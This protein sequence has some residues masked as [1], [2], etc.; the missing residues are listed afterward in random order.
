M[1]V[2]LLS[3]L[4][5]AA[6]PLL[7]DVSIIVGDLE[8]RIEREEDGACS[9][10][11]RSRAATCHTLEEG[12]IAASNCTLRA[13]LELAQAME[14]V[15]T[16]S[17]TLTGG[18]FLLSG[19]LPEVVGSVQVTGSVGRG[20]HEKPRCN[21][22][23]VYCTMDHDFVE[24]S[25]GHGQVQPIGTV[26]DGGGR[27]P[28]LRL[29]KF[30]SLAVNTLRLENG[31][32]RAC[33]PT[34]PDIELINVGVAR[35]S[36]PGWTAQ[37]GE[38]GC[39]MHA[40]GGAIFSVGGQLV[41]TNTAIR[42]NRATFGG[43]LYVEGEAEVHQSNVDHNVASKCGGALYASVGSRVLFDKYKF[44]N[45]KDSCQQ[46][47]VPP[48]VATDQEFKY[49]APA[50]RRLANQEGAQ[51]KQEDLNSRKWGGTIYEGPPLR[52]PPP[53]PRGYGRYSLQWLWSL[54]WPSNA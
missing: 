44:Q 2:F 38:G 42:W 52:L 50:E 1:R 30:S 16:V 4:C 54:A 32:A 35:S 34:M 33:D 40:A 13:A 10:I 3:A 41:L 12:L 26:I 21:S 36:E 48:R 37:I 5:Q 15:S 14:G 51:G 22:K 19:P 43:G 24:D 49:G 39:V 9:P 31:N 17:I 29:G 46:H 23:N 6:H 18:R 20:P 27:F 53:A 28:I 11:P 7:P 25:K 8:D 47:A 45:N